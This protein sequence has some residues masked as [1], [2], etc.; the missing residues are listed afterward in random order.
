MQA[1]DIAELARQQAAGSSRYLEFLRV[2]DLSLGLYVLPAGATD[3][4]KPHTEPEVYYVVGGAATVTVGDEDRPV[5]PG[6]IIFVD[7]HVPHRFHTITA[8]LTLLVV[9]APAEYARQTEAA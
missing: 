4:Q 2:P 1:F 5:G 8:D 3:G 6:A 9:F 7:A